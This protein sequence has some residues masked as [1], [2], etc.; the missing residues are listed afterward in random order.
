MGAVAHLIRTPTDFRLTVGNHDFVQRNLCKVHPDIE[1]EFRHALDQLFAD[2]PYIDAT[3]LNMV[4]VFL[5]DIEEPLEALQELGATLFAIES[6]GKLKMASGEDVP[7]W[8]RVYYLIIPQGAYF[9]IGQDIP[10][11]VIHRFNPQCNDAIRALLRAAIKS[12]HMSIWPTKEGLQADYEG[13]VL[14]CVNCGLDE[15]IV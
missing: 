14:W 2:L 4:S 9:A 1:R 7:E 13:N 8:S 11:Q 5:D 15:I 3:D 10:D 12:E 6:K